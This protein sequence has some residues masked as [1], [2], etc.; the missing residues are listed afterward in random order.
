MSYSYYLIRCFWN[1]ITYI[2][3]IVIWINKPI[4]AFL[5]YYNTGTRFGRGRVCWSK[6]LPQDDFFASRRPLL[7][8][9]SHIVVGLNGDVF[10]HG[11]VIVGVVVEG[12]SVPDV[13]KFRI[14][15]IS[16]QEL[17]LSDFDDFKKAKKPKPKDKITRSSAHIQIKQFFRDFAFNDLLSMMSICP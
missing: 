14:F 9:V 13:F 16:K 7:C 5:S 3:A 6:S 2:S 10:P 11:N 12:G 8:S 1:G 15:W 4:I 17:K